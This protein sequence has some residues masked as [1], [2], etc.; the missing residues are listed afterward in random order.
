M[1]R[2][3]AQGEWR[4]TGCVLCA[5]N[6]GL[7]V[8]IRDNRLVKS[9]PDKDNPRSRGYACRK[10]LNVA[11]HQHHA[12]RLRRPL[13]RV[14]GGFTPIGWDQALDEIAGRLKGIVGQYGP[15]S[16]A[17]VGG[18]GQGCHFEAAF[19]MRLLRGLGSRYFYGPL[20]QELT[21]L[22]WV[23]GRAT[24]RQY[25]HTIP[26]HDRTELLLAVGWNGWMSHQMPQ[27]RRALTR[28]SRDPERLL[29]VI[30]PRRSETAARADIHLSLRPGTDAL[31]T[32]AMIKII[33]DQ[34]WE[35]RAFLETRVSGWD[36]VKG[37]F[38]G[39]DQAEA[40]RV[41][42]LDYG[43][44][45][46][47]CRLLTTKRWSMHADLGI[48]MNR[49]ST[50]TSY[51]EHVLLCVCGRIGVE[52]GNVF[53]GYLMPLGAHSDER[54]ERTWRTLA[55]GF[56]AILGTF[57]PNVLPREILADHPERL[58]AVLVSG[59]NPLRSYA[60]TRAYEEAFR[61]LD[62][63]VTTELALTETAALSDY[64]LP[65]R[66]GYESWDGTF[67]AWTYP[68]VFF[69]MRRPV[70]EP[71]GEPKEV[72][73]VYTLLAERLGLIPEIP[74]EVRAAAGAGR[75]AFG[76]ALMSWLGQEPKVRAALPFILARTLGEELG[77]ANLAALW[78]LLMT[79]PQGFRENA[80][81]AGF[82]PGPGQGEEI[83]QALLDNPQGVV[84][85]RCD[86][87]ANLA[88]LKTPDGRLNVHVPEMEEWVAS[89]EPGREEES[90]KLPE[91]YPLIL[92]AG[93]HMDL[94]AN[95]LMRDPAWNKGRRAC[96]L[97]MSQADAEGLGLADGERVRVVTEA[98]QAELELE[99][100]P[101]VREGMVIIPHGFGLDHEGRVYGVNV[102]RLTSGAHRD[103]LAGTPLHRFVPC[104]VEAVET[105]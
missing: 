77:S 9:R 38:Q 41:C 3:T 82:A 90:L 98:G 51:L 17:Y 94:N 57:P 59:S 85:G 27:A 70:V 2:E 61:K 83:F 30:D 87:G 102:N 42:G 24:G 13:K 84:I 92:N 95:T 12:G 60:D 80:A 7:E 40:V 6:C 32:R 63:L 88:G 79:A 23:Q 86:E 81:R 26:D 103:K 25:L 33:L 68:E 67:F 5:Q 21:G 19:G 99:R 105:A 4:K 100:D 53:P 66:S 8:L 76:A 73:Q 56:P 36:E 14:G 54:E 45:E 43:L 58:R 11:F 29:V 22:Y 49:H 97:A 96:T 48:L 55:T 89:I 10:G 16:V 62:L 44:V 1:G 31:L 69:Q 71:E 78:G 46:E 65:A 91:E 15:R 93:R 20:G 104:R 74:G 52:G 39:F 34:G 75:A 35:D 72:G 28:I 18:G 64:V 50:A 47:V 101:S 37:W